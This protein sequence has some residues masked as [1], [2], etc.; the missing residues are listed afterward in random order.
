MQQDHRPI[1][2]TLDESLGQNFTEAF[3]YLSVPHC[4]QACVAPPFSK[5]NF[6]AFFFISLPCTLSFP[7]LHHIFILPPQAPMRVLQHPPTYSYIPALAFLYTGALSLSGPFVS[8][9]I[10]VQH[11]HPLLYILLEQ[12]VPP[13]G[14]AE[15]GRGRSIMGSQ[16]IFCGGALS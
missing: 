7:F 15:G 14:F 2:V 12:W 13:C 8:P 4:F 16:Y 9:H 5:M 11:G 1:H 3:L 6:R 10:D